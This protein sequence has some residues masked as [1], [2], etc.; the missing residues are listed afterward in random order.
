MTCQFKVINNRIWI[1]SCL[2]DFFTSESGWI[3]YRHYPLTDHGAYEG[4]PHHHYLKRENFII[5]QHHLLYF[6]Y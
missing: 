3:H 4:L 1:W 5:L 2:I 6:R